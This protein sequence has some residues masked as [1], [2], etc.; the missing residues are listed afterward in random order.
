MKIITTRLDHI[1]KYPENTLTNSEGR[2]GLRFSIFLHFADAFGV[3][4]P[5]THAT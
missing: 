1:T 5:F 2:T 3:W 4:G